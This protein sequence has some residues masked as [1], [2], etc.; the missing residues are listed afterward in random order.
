MTT[1]PHVPAPPPGPGVH[2]PFPA[3][4]VEGR[5]KRL[6]LSLGIAAGV[7]VLVCG[8]GVAALTGLI[9][10]GTSAL[11]EQAQVAV[12]DY[13][14]AVQAQK[15]EQAYGLL[16]EQAKDDES[17]AEFRTRLTAADPIE[18]YTL[19]DLNYVDLSVPV[20]ARYA[21]GASRELDAYLG[22]DTGTGEFEV[23]RLAE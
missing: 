11:T 6:G 19:G 22:Q 16:C 4:P 9:S 7:L 23:C 17:P 21:G 15:Y 18:S 3:P 2:P 14:D 8:G 12:R 10:S 5:G 1:A 20:N 13:L